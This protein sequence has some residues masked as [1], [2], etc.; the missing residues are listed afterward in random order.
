M[1]GEVDHRGSAVVGSQAAVGGLA[2]CNGGKETITVR[3]GAFAIDRIQFVDG[4]F[5]EG[6]KFIDRNG[7]GG[8]V[9][10]ISRGGRLGT[11]RALLWN[12]LCL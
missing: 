11:R 4:S 10:S 6:S 12:L 3:R 1:R 7:I 9:V 5:R 2:E 8:A